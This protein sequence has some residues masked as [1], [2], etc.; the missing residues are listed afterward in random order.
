MAADSM[1]AA[2]MAAAVVVNKS[3][4]GERFAHVEKATGRTALVQQRQSNTCFTALRQ[5]HGRGVGSHISLHPARMSGVD[6]DLR[7]L[8]FVRQMNSERVQGRLRRIVRQRLEAIDRTAG[9]GMQALGTEDARHIHNP[10][11][12]ALFE[13]GQQRLR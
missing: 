4:P 9:V 2:V 6:F 7:V 3:L 1:A 11:G 12:V 13:Q 5:F 8:Q 10:P